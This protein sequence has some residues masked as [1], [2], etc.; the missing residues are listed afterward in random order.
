MSYKASTFKDIQAIAQNAL[1]KVEDKGGFKNVVCVACGGTHGT[2]YPLEYF[3]RAESNIAVY[4]MNA[5]E[6]SSNPLKCVGNNSLVLAGSLS[7]GTKEV[8]EAIKVAKEKGAIVYALTGVY[9]SKI[10][11]EA[12]FTS[13]YL[14]EEPF[15]T[16]DT[17]IQFQCL[18]MANELVHAIEENYDKY[19][20]MND[21]FAKISGITTKAIKK[22]EKRAKEFG[23][24]YKD[25]PLIYTI[26]S[27][28]SEFV[29]YMQSICMFM[30]MEWI[31]SSSI[32]SA[33]YFHGP[34]EVTDP[35]T[36]FMFFMSAGK[37]RKLDERAYNFL[38]R[39]GEKIILIDAAELGLNT[40]ND[41]VVTYF[42]PLL[43]YPVGLVY[44]LGIA[45]AKQHPFFNR[46]YMGHVE[47]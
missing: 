3:L 25:E 45:E 4:S 35:D 46:R 33:E 28:A 26:A 37:T 18:V 6:F 22:I 10:E 29:A 2:F 16:V 27:G 44:A 5:A 23:Q 21:G 11:K 14:P 39:Y 1:K 8:L 34:F 19:D 42:N 38:R 30:E 36:P 40:I 20:S 15:N 31:H 32:N 9:D 7:G 41:D 47:Y 24:E 12:D 13:F 43:L 17:Q